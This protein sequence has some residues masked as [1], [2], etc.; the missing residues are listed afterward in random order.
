[1]KKYIFFS[2]LLL[3]FSLFSAAKKDTLKVGTT[4]GYAPFVSLNEKN[5]YEGFDIDV[6]KALS[7]K[8]QV[9][10]N[11]KDLGSMPALMLGLKQNKVDIIIWA[12]SITEKR[13]KNMEMIYYSGDIVD[14][15]PIIF[16]NKI[17]ANIKSFEDLKKDSKNIICVEAGSYQEEVFKSC[18]I[19]LKYLNS[20]NDVILDLKYKKSFA[21][22]ID[23]SL[24][25]LYTSKNQNL[26]VLTLELPD[27]YKSM[28]FGICL[29][30]SNKKLIQKIK[31]SN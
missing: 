25:G 17:P 10:Y 22:A 30:K 16:W 4:S 26:K 11:I 5:E 28:G 18:D 6:V 29:N 8:L 2:F 9:S 14:K 12:I 31:K 23:P 24:V 1:M 7:D 15:M 27:K 20:I 21:S 19:P 13:L 3:T